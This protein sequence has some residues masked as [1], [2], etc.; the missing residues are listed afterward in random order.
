MGLFESFEF[1]LQALHKK[2][3]I[4]ELRSVLFLLL[5]RFQSVV[6][7]FVFDLENQVLVKVFLVIGRLL[8][9]LMLMGGIVLLFE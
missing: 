7:D 9:W 8:L 4:L 6:D 1:L 3:V 2:L 5:W